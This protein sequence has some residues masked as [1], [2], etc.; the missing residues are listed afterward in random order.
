[1]LPH[2]FISDFHTE[3][4]SPTMLAFQVCPSTHKNACPAI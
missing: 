4:W 2:N 3:M 1:V